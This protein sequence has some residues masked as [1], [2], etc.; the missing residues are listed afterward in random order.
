MMSR[1]VPTSRPAP[2]LTPAVVGVWTGALLLQQG[3]TSFL[4]MQSSLPT[5]GTQEVGVVINDRGRTLLADRIGALVEQVDGRLEN[6]DA[7]AITL[8]VARVTD[9]RGTSSNW[10]G[11]RVSIPTEAIA[12]YRPKTFSKFK[13]GLF[14]GAVTAIIL[15]TLRLSLDIFGVPTE[16]P[17][18]GSPQQS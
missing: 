14:L 11:E 6:R 1:W 3:C 2:R 4:P 12:G 17:T 8:R 13:T 7:N 10:T 15:T 16:G 5:T 9:V 18:T